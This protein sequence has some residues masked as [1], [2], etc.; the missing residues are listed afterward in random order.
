MKFKVYATKRYKFY[1]TII[2]VE[3]MNP[4]IRPIFI[5][6]CFKLRLIDRRFK[7]SGFKIFDVSPVGDTYTLQNEYYLE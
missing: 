1:S 5:G 6:M 2:I 7:N 3:S 4:V